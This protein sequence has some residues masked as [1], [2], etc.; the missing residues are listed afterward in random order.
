MAKKLDALSQF[1]P[2]DLGI[3]ITDD[4]GTQEQL[5]L[6][7]FVPKSI[8]SW[9]AHAVESLVAFRETATEEEHYAI[10]WMLQMI[11]VYEVV[12]ELDQKNDRQFR[13]QSLA[14]SPTFEE[15]NAYTNATHKNTDGK[16]RSY[17]G[18]TEISLEDLLSKAIYKNPNVE[19]QVGWDAYCDFRDDFIYWTAPIF[20]PN[21]LRLNFDE[22]VSVENRQSKIHNPI[23]GF[24]TA[25][26]AR[27]SS[28]A[29]T[30]APSENNHVDLSH[31]FY[32]L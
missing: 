20:S 8:E 25:L 23:E 14:N 19:L 11:C 17:V 5:D 22:S 28:D 16:I 29:E 10:D 4:A 1:D 26:T 24:S 2:C 15:L 13:P 21:A 31:S 30:G 3:S 27:P 7:V 32:R 6:R 9:I 12:P 18:V